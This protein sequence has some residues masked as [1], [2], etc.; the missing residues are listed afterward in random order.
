MNDHFSTEGAKIGNLTLL[1]RASYYLTIEIG[2][3][4]LP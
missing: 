4:G 2:L 3:D 1:F